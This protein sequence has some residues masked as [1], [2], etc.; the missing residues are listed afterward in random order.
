MEDQNFE[1][2][3]D[4]AQLW[5]DGYIKD[6]LEKLMSTGDF[7]SISQLL[8]IAVNNLYKDYEAQGRIKPKKPKPEEMVKIDE[9]EIE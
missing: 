9:G 1:I 5:L 8:H 6:K 3:G 7:K 2:K 4:R